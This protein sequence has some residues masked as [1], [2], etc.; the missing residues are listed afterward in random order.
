[1]RDKVLAFCR[2]EGLFAPG[3]Q[4]VCALSGGIDSVAMLHCLLQLGQELEITVTAAHYNHCLRGEAS[5]EDE[6][7]VRRLCASWGVPLAVG[8]GDVA[9]FAA[10]AG[11][12]VEE[13]ARVMRYDFLLAQPGVVAVAHH[14]D[15]QVETVLLNLL[16]GTGLR[17]L[18]G[19]MPKTDRVV[20]PLMTVTRAEIL[21]YGKSEGLSWREDESNGQ[22]DA[23]RNRLRH[24][25]LPLL[26]EEN[27]NLAGTVERM[28]ELLRRDES[29]L[30]AQT[31]DLLRR[32]CR[33]GGYD[34]RMLRQAPQVLCQRA[35]RRLLEIPKPTMAHVLG[36]VELLQKDSGSGELPLPGGYVFRNSYGLVSLQRTGAWSFAPVELRPGQRI[37][38]SEAGLEIALSEPEVL[39]K[40]MKSTSTFA[41]KCDM[42]RADST[43]SVRPRQTGDTLRLSGGTKSVKKLM[44]DRK[45]PAYRRNLCPVLTDGEGIIA[46]YGLGVD[47]AW[48]AAPGDRAVMISIT[49]REN[50]D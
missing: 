22:D 44:I 42:M 50:H 45:I 2:R 39:E 27:P 18:G 47:R 25:V 31:E 9:A 34:A 36:A 43:I 41:I 46:V 21:A 29:Y 48:A 26:Q 17:G 6:A 1:M 40:N 30:Q 35:I 11:R 24:H 15:D 32:A 23:L 16:R 4:V 14:G 38:I 10:E 13:A 37:S 19:M 33:P 8:R 12:S 7:F 20:R 28:T 5:Q 49:R 3:T